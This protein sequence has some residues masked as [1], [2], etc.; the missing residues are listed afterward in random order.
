V[1]ILSLISSE[2]KYGAESMLVALSRAL[3]GLGHE[4]VVGVFRDSRN[5]H[6]EVAEEAVRRGLPVEFIPCEGRWDCDAVRRI[7]QLLRE[8]K[9][10]ILHSH[11]YKSNLYGYAAARRKGIALVSTCHNWPNRPLVMRG[12]AALDRLVLRRFDRI[13]AVSETVTD[14][15][16]NSG[17]APGKLTT[18]PNG[19]DL[20]RFRGA[21][22]VLRTEFA[23]GRDPLI[24]F[25]GRFVQDKGGAILLA[26]A[27]N[28][29]ESRPDA[30]FVFVGDG[31]LRSEWEALAGRLGIGGRVIFAGA[32]SDMPEVYASLDMVVLPSLNEGMPMCLLEALAAEKPVIATAVG[33]IPRIILPGITGIL[34]EPGDATG[35]AAA[36]QLVLGDTELA[37]RLARNGRSRAAESFSSERMAASYADLYQEAVDSRLNAA[38]VTVTCN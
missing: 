30:R 2:G 7:S 36:V 8:R 29:V 24:G 22:P 37:A 21:Q 6:T 23:T 9:I 34:L 31:P 13:A 4:V 3:F 11:G 32:R 28:V 33:A 27:S 26:A 25:V 17:V 16:K 5:P 38:A 20:E 14:I 10:D 19:V 18:I 1:R 35:L 12:Y 15:L